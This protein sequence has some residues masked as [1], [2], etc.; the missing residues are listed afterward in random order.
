MCSIL[1]MVS[2]KTIPKK[3]LMQAPMLLD[4]TTDRG[5][6]DR[7]SIV[8]DKRVYLGS[9]RLNIIDLSP[10]GKMPMKSLHG[11]Y[12]ISYNGE[13]YNY[14]SLREQ[15]VNEGFIFQSTAD[16][17]VILNAYVY[18]G[19]KFI[20][21]LNGIFAF[22]IF[23]KKNNKI[24]AGRDRFGGK[25][26]YYSKINDCIIFSS[27]FTVLRDL[28][29]PNKKEIDL[30]ALTAYM[31]CRF[32]PGERTILKKIFKLKP[33]EI[34]T[35][36]VEN[37]SST[38]RQFWRPKF[39]PTPF[40]QEEFNTK[41]NEAIRYTKIADL[42]PSILLSGG[43]DSA[44]IAAILYQQG[45]NKIQTYTCAFTN[46]DASS[47]INKPNYQITTPNIDERDR[48][49][50]IADIFKYK[51]ESFLI[52]SDIGLDG[53][54]KMQQVLG[55]PIAS[56]N[57]LGSYLFALALKGRTKLA[58]A[59]TGS[60]ELLGGYQDLYFKG[61]N[62]ALNN[63]DDPHTFLEAFADFDTGL[64]SPLKYLK[65]ELV[66]T[67]Y[68]MNYANQAMGLFPADRYPNELL[69]QL[70]FFE[71]A[72]ALPG[73]ELDQA[74]RLFMSQSIELRPAFLENNFV[75]YTLTIPSVN[76]VNKRPLKEAMQKY[77]PRSVTNQVK[78]P[79]LGTPK[80]V[81]NQEWFKSALN[82]LF[83]ETLDIWD[84]DN[85]MALAKQPSAGWNF[86]ILYRLVY[87]QLWLT[88]NNFKI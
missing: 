34:I 17:E 3:L 47:K 51:N 1:G 26:L 86:D 73:W 77:L 63:I 9:N 58:L 84:K 80:N 10:G 67:G 64:I 41:L 23:D 76:K 6:D 27:D 87:L 18:W 11:D 54:I 19:D 74:D 52:D 31:Q 69:N 43:L 49:K 35:W 61:K 36:K 66:Q 81:C 5:P 44:A 48:A 46:P 85:V 82:C 78:Y 32:V 83:N 50:V 59:G 2:S 56:T 72:F 70:S 4:I 25:P 45:D 8:I 7:G 16:T 37:L 62:T 29:Y 13:I 65:P 15:L 14:I 30:S 28:V 79:G 53:F 40:L 75:D 24:I 39:E 71:I 33:A 60:D 88:D 22:L 38:A 68:L 42:S 57:A 12:W 20:E 21:K 55:E